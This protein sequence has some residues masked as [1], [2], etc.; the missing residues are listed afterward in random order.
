MAP[1]QGAKIEVRTKFILVERDIGC[2]TYGT[3][4]IVRGGGLKEVV[5]NLDVVSIDGYHFIQ[6]EKP[7]EVTSEILSYFSSQTS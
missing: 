6:Q 1:W 2:N 4:M 5:P 3:G 7:D